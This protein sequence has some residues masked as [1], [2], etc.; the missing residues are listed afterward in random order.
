MNF[1]YEV[2]K[3]EKEYN[4]LL[5]AI[6]KG[7]LP[8]VASGLSLITK[9]VITAALKQ[10]LNKKILLLTHDEASAVNMA[11]NLTSMG[12]ETLFFPSRDYNLTDMASFSR[13]YEHRRIDTLSKCLDGD[14]GVVSLSIEAAM[15]YTI[16]PSVLADA[17][18]DNIIF[19]AS[20]LSLLVSILNISF[21]LLIDFISKFLNSTPKF[22][23]CSS[24]FK[25]KSLPLIL[26]KPG[27]F[28][29]SLVKFICPPEKF[30]SK[31]TVL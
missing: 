9:S 11:D 24:I 2:L 5:S 14:F 28:S 13:E 27:K 6:E 4:A 7:R 21:S 10:H 8:L 1:L 19:F 16:P 18:N 26:E 23:A 22:F 29:I 3:Q 12:I 31:T 17:P 20:K 30:F 25:A 15:Q